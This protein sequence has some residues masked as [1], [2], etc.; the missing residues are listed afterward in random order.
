ML[1]FEPIGSDLSP[2]E[3]VAF[4]PTVLSRRCVTGR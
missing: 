2:E 3:R 4:A 1:G